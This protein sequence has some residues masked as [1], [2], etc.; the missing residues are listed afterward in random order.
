MI[1]MLENKCK[2]PLSY[3]FNRSKDNLRSQR[4]TKRRQRIVCRCTLQLITGRS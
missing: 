1:L 4:S 3:R 2:M